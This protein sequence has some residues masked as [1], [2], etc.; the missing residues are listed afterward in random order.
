MADLTTYTV[1]A[2]GTAFS[3]YEEQIRFDS[4][5]AISEHF[6]TP[7]PYNKSKPAPPMHITRDPILFGIIVRHLSG[8][9][10]L[11]LTE[12]GLPAGMSVD[13]AMKNLIQDAQILRLNKLLK[14]LKAPTLPENISMSWAGV[15][16]TLVP[17]EDL[18]DEEFEP[19]EGDLYWHSRNDILSG[20]DGLPVLILA[21][22]VPV[23]YVI[24]R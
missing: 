15:S 16:T 8:I 13:A 6:D 19:A 20:D 12:R 17:L 1:Y 14:L 5:N 7:H 11:P 9:Q 10:I 18:A 3:L 2:Q 4:P 21:K 24:T 22:N 23:Q